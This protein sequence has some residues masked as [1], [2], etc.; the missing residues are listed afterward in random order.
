MLLALKHANPF[1]LLV[2]FLAKR[3]NFTVKIIIFGL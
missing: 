1:V 3:P 2:D